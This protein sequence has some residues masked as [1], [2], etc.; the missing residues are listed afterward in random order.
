[1][2]AACEDLCV[3]WAASEGCQI[4]EGPCGKGCAVDSRGF[5]ER[6]LLAA[7]LY[8]ECSLGVAWSCPGAPDVPETSDARCADEEKEWLSCKVT[9]APRPEASSGP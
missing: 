3:V 4:P 6:C 9:G 1:M 5:A 7:R 8:Y 2:R